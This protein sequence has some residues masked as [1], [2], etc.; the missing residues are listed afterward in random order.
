MKRFDDSKAQPNVAVWK[1]VQ[2]I[3]DR[4]VRP[5]RLMTFARF[6]PIDRCRHVWVHASI[7]FERGYFGVGPSAR[8]AGMQRAFARRRRLSRFDGGTNRL[9]RYER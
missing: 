9:A 6:G 1:N 2:S 4:V 8:V 5:I 7:A 3:P